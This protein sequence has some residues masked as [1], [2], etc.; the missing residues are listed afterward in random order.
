M[1]ISTWQVFLRRLILGSLGVRL[2][3]RTLQTSGR[4][5]TGWVRPQFEVLETRL[6][7]A[8]TWI[9]EGPGPITGGQVEGLGTQSS[10]AAGAVKAVV[11]DP[12]NANSLWIGTVNGGVW[13]T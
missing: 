8:A 4:R 12:T 9:A 7:L 11:A 13:H 1:V 10:P 5:R 6:L 3:S 2:A